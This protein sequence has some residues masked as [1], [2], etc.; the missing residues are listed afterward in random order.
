MRKGEFANGERVLRAKIGM[1]SPNINL[2]DRSSTGSLTRIIIIQ[3]T[4]GAFI[5]CTLLPI[6]W[7]MP[8][9]GLRIPVLLEF[10]DQ[11]PF[12]DWVVAECEMDSTPHQYEFGRLNVAQ[13]VTS[14]RKLKRLVDE[15]VVDGWD[16]PR[17]PTISDFAAWGIRLKPFATSCLRREFRR[18]TARWTAK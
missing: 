11:R 1:A 10:E 12:Y 17:M 6:R 13:T 8:L 15:N 9:K 2:R 18:R 3:A 14:K 16:D 5:R 4:S 7:R